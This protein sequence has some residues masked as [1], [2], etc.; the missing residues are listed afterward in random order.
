M[1]RINIIGT[2]NRPAQPAFYVPNRMDEPTLRALVQELGGAEQVA[3]LVEEVLLPDAATM[4]FIRR[5]EQ[6]VLMFNFRRAD[7]RVLREQM[8]SLMGQGLDIIFVPGRPNSIPG[9]I[10]DVPMPFMM[11]LGGQLHHE[12]HGHV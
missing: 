10:S 2:E 6:N 8:L 4:R 9:C 7:S 3:F 11:Q 5:H 12:R 1:A